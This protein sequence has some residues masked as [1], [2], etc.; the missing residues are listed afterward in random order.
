MFLKLSINLGRR[1][2]NFGKTL[3]TKFARA[4]G[5]RI[6]AYHGGPLRHR[7]GCICA[8][9]LGKS[10]NEIAMGTILTRKVIPRRRNDFYRECRCYE[11]VRPMCLSYD[12]LYS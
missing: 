11:N 2:V 1:Q 7:Q 8:A 10:H 3:A 5:A 9:P 12:N 6:L 4:F